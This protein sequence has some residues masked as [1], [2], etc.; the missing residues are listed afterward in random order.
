[1]IYFVISST[2]FA[3]SAKVAEKNRFPVS[4]DGDMLKNSLMSVSG[5]AGPKKI[6]LLLHPCR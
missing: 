5:A 2:I 3:R 6:R 1:M 4:C